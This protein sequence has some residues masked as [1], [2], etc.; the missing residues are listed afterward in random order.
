MASPVAVPDPDRADRPDPIVGCS[1]KG[2]L[3]ST[4]IPPLPPRFLTHHGVVRT[5]GFIG[6]GRQPL[7][8]V[9]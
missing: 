5:S 1:L 3:R 2:A 6:P 8:G 9:S 7:Q 4:N